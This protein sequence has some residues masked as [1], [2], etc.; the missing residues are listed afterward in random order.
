MGVRGRPVEG[1]DYDIG[2]VLVLSTLA[3]DEARLLGTSRYSISSPNGVS[4]TPTVVHVE[5]CRIRCDPFVER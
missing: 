2:A 5:C 1:F 3:V 4:T